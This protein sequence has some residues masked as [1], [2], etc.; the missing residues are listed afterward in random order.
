MRPAITQAINDSPTEPVCRRT[1][2]GDAKI[3]EPIIVPV[4]DSSTS[5][6]AIRP[7]HAI[8]GT[9]VPNGP[10]A[11]MQTVEVVSVAQASEQLLPTNYH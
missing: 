9:T 11:E 3:P 1:V 2:P 5:A 6:A 10:A 7:L 8:A 4:A